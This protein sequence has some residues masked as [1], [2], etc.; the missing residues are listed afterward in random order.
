MFNEE[1]V[2]LLF[3]KTREKRRGKNEIKSGAV[4]A[5]LGWTVEQRVE[6]GGEEG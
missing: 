5:E 3:C 2:L 1:D 4:K 6:P